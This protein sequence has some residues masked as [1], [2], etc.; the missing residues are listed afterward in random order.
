MLYSVIVLDEIDHL[1]ASSITMEQV[2]ALAATHKIR[3]HLRI[4]GISNTHTLTHSKPSESTLTLHFEPYTSSQMKAILMARLSVLSSND[5]TANKIFPLP[6][7]SLLS[8]K[9]AGRT[10]DIR[11]VFSVA[12]RALDAAVAA[13]GPSSSISVTPAHIIAAL[14]ASN[15]TIGNAEKNGS[16]TVSRVRDL[17]LQHRFVLA[18]LLLATK[19]IIAGLPL[20]GIVTSP[21]KLKQ[22]SSGTCDSAPSVDFTA[23]HGYY[24]TILTRGANAAFSAVNRTE[25][26]DLVN[27][28]EGNGLVQISQSRGK[29]K[30]A[31]VKG[32]GIQ[33]VCIA[34]G[35]REEELVRGLTGTSDADHGPLDV[36]EE[37]VRH[38]WEKE[39]AR[40]GRET[41]IRDAKPIKADFEDAEED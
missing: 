36:K 32:K 35:V 7:I 38:L 1:T 4:I 6:T 13:A 40:L 17:G 22:T 9:I 14:K 34:S 15:A 30:S 12:R 33:V 39:L 25:F 21:I 31:V 27:I 8:M 20:T 28:L 24:C 5:P 3:S 29:I 19:R 41:N 26:A 10:G 2:F 37:E 23:L 18:S 11:T 16:E